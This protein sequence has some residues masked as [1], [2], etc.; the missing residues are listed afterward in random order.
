MKLV[1]KEYIENKKVILRL[2]LNVPIKD[3]IIL[4]NTKI[5]KSLKT[6]EFLLDNNCKIIILSH[7]GRI[8]KE[9]DKV[10]YTLKPVAEELKKL[11][12]INIGFKNNF[13]FGDNE[14]SLCEKI[15]LFENTRYF[16]IDCL[17]SGCNE[18]LSEY[19]ASFGDVFINDAF[20]T[21]H[22]KHASNYGIK[23]FKPSYY[24]FLV[25][26][27]IQNLNKIIYVKDRP[28]VVFMGGAKVDDKL[29]LIESL[30]EKCDYLLLGG[31]ILNSFL[32]A[33]NV[34]VKKSLASSDEIVLQNI[35][36]IYEKNA[37]KI[38]LN[39]NLVWNDDKIVDIDI[40]NYTKYLLNSR[41]IFINGT[42]GLYENKEFEK[43]TK[44]LYKVLGDSS[45]Y[46]IVG[47]G[48]AAASIKYFN[49]DKSVDY[50]S[51]GGGAT[52]S[53]ISMGNLVALED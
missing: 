8:K 43:G 36:R 7:L 23:K 10:L 24:G 35:K 41:L 50:I 25:E 27:E 19:F 34:D 26:D 15:T 11:L 20:G 53:Y 2:D 9:E 18:K 22:R 28:F 40:K 33:I 38:I 51:T 29:Q 4:D 6:I 32:K 1:K 12:G 16:D 46:K 48:D 42:P 21:S 5:V 3:G 30:L 17:E 39:S 13:D 45:A 49:L 47:G 37:S 44:E 14:E 31:G 52:L